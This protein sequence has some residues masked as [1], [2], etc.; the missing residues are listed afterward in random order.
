MIPAEIREIRRKKFSEEY[1][2]KYDSMLIEQ[3][4]KIKKHP[5]RTL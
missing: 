1:T 4:I 2:Y 5:M 3:T